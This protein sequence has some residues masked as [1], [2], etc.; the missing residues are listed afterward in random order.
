MDNSRIHDLKLLH[1]RFNDTSFNMRGRQAAYRKYQRIQARCKD[2]SLIK[3][4]N[5]LVNAHQANDV[6]ETDKIEQ[7]ARAYVWRT[8]GEVP[9][10]G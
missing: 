5:R 10:H 3:L 8:Y 1:E 7:L 4:R 9:R 2:R 6:D